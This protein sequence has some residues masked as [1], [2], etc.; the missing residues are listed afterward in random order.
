MAGVEFLGSDVG[1][2][3]RGVEGVAETG[4]ATTSRE[5][6]GCG[7]LAD[8]SGLVPN[9]LGLAFAVALSFLII[10]ILP[11]RVGVAR[12]VAGAGAASVAGARAVSVAGEATSRAGAEAALG[13][14][15]SLSASDAICSNASRRAAACSGLSSL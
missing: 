1:F 9:R 14:L 10:I 4:V 8:F 7:S 15:C 2:F 13:S 11:R 3:V 12:A 5:E 6:L